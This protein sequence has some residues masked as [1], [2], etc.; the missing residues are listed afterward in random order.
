MSDPACEDSLPSK[1][2]FQEPRV[3]EQALSDENVQ[4]DCLGK[5]GQTLFLQTSLNKVSAGLP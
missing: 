2:P 1:F 4:H 5:I 3:Y